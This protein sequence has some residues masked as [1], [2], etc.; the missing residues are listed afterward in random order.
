MRPSD[1]DRK[2]IAR[3]IWAWSRMDQAEF[4]ERAGLTHARIR[5]I[6][7]QDPKK[8]PPT[9]D[10][11]LSMADAAGVPEAFV[12]HGFTALA[13]PVGLEAQV[14]ELLAAVEALT[15]DNARHHRALQ[16]LGVGDL[17]EEPQARDL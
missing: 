14:R 13:G 1:E 10:E 6:L 9:T 4:A 15:L 7:G 16:A 11:L 12:L 5:A 8:T 17:P 2:R 3:A